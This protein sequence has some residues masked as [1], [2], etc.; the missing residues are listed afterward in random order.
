MTKYTIADFRAQYATE[1]SCLDKIFVLRY[2]KLEACPECQCPASFRRITT[3]RCYQCTE[4]YAQFYPT[5]GTVFEKTRTPLIHWF[6]VIYLFTTTRNGLAAKEIQRQLGVTYKCAFRLGHKVRNLISGLRPEQLQGLVEVD[7]TYIGGKNK[8]KHWDKRQDGLTGGG[9]MAIAFG[10]MEREGRVMTHVLTDNKVKTIRDAV[11]TSIKEGSIVISDEASAYKT[12]TDKYFHGSVNHNRGE[13]ARAMI[14]TNSIE[15]FWAQV[16]R[17]IGGT[18]IGVSDK[19]LPN[20]LDECCF[21]YNHRKAPT[22][23]FDAI[24]NQLPIVTEQAQL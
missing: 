14:H 18:H 22:T 24:I 6:Y 1:E 17:T 15:G 21:R 13:Y 20:Y 4:C 11:Y 7:E 12:I 5:A 16:K 19:Y 8:N 3:R 9:N 23:M 10:A 2:G